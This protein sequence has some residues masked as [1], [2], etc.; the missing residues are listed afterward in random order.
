MAGL[1]VNWTKSTIYPLSRY[2]PPQHLLIGGLQIPR[3]I[4]AVRYLGVRLYHLPQGIYE[5][6]YRRALAGARSSV[7]FWKDLPLAPIGKIAVAKMILVP[8]LLYFFVNL[9]VVPPRSFFRELDALLVTLIWG[10]GRR[11]IALTKLQLPMD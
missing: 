9:L 8:R 6:N 11:R 1:K 2:L 5:G 3:S 7:N 10:S 4:D